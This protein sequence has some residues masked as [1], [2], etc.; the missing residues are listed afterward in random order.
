MPARFQR[1]LL[2]VIVFLF[3]GLVTSLALADDESDRRG[4]LNDIDSR[5]GS[6]YSELSGVRSD[7][8]DGD[9]R[10]AD[11]YVDQVRDLVSRLDRVKGDDA[12]AREVVDRYPGYVD[13]F[14]RAD[15]ALRNMKGYQ[16]ANVTLM[17]VCQ[18]KNNELIAQA[19]D[20]EDRNDPEG[21]EKLPRAAADAKNLTVR[22]LEEAEKFRAQLEDWKR[23]VQ[24][25]D[26]SEGKWN[27]LKAILR[28]ES[29]DIY[30]YWKSD[31]DTAKE[32][33]NDLMA[34]PDH[35]AVRAVLGKLAGSSAGRKEVT[36]NLIRLINELAAK[37]K[38][39]P[40]AS[41]T[42][43][44][45]NARE[46]L[47]AI[48]STLAILERT[49]G[50]DRTAK[51]LAETW[52]AIAREAR[53][54]LEPLKLLKEQHHA[55]DDL[56]AKCKD[57]EAKLDAWIATNG[58]DVDGID[59]LPDFAKELGNPVVVGMAKAKELIEKMKVARDGAQRFTR[60]EVP[61]AEVASAYRATSIAI[62]DFI[63]AG[64]NTTEAAC[65]EIVKTTEHPRVKAAVDKLKANNGSAADRLARRGTELRTQGAA[66]QT[67]YKAFET[68]FW[69]HQNASK[70]LRKHDVDE[71]DQ[72]IIFTCGQDHERDGDEAEVLSR[73]MRERTI[74]AARS[75]RD[76]YV[77]RADDLDARLPSLYATLRTLNDDLDAAL[78]EFEGVKKIDKS[79]VQWLRDQRAEVVALRDKNRD[80]FFAMMRSDRQSFLNTSDG[81][82]NGENN[83][84]T[85][86]AS[87]YGRDRH[88]ALQGDSTFGCAERE[89]AAGGGFAD[90]ISHTQCTV[91]EFK[92]DSWSENDAL[93]QATRYLPDVKKAFSAETSAG[94]AWEHC[95]KPNGPTSGDGYR[96]KAY[97]Y[98]KCTP[99]S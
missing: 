48:D 86:A 70:Q 66:A 77:R 76:E 60:S 94:K 64:Y 19:K 82:L 96:T 23:N 91:W 52:P 75:R 3:A 2:I 40:G 11:N 99:G 56:P 21:L 30:S 7:A 88:R 28:S 44:V 50:S 57:L 69:N 17:K 10:D 98:P 53:P 41:G 43:A 37:L 79:Q 12:R 42:Y 62:Y 58:D 74:A 93:D 26:V 38:E 89:F 95:W 4:L 55:F 5:L 13:K 90:C 68:E 45:D 73:A 25:F 9:I 61:W 18:D 32:R 24:Y 36:E 65:R 81:I 84:R 54:P 31:Q 20:F 33:C 16:N 97:R 8:D 87:K 46:K 27:D 83:P 49:K 71:L 78:K 29:D 35:P 59:K 39:V 6:A 85:A 15:T 92:P 47:D 63:E 14:K 34:G 51:Q 80:T 1:R 22:F 67:T 72:L